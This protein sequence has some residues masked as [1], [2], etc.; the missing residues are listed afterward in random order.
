MTTFT[1]A[2]FYKDPMAAIAWLQRVFGFEVASL[3]T[4]P[5]GKLA[6]SELTYRG[7]ALNIG[8]SLAVEL[9]AR[10]DSC[11]STDDIVRKYPEFNSGSHKL[12]GF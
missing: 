6:H 10:D 3:I 12:D 2:V 9:I 1:P 4:D 11:V 8:D 7:G 5:D